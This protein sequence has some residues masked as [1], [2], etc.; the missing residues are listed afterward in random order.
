MFE[1]QKPQSNEMVIFLDVFDVTSK[2]I[3]I[4]ARR[5][6]N[7]TT[8]WLR[9]AIARKVAKENKLGVGLIR[10]SIHLEK[11]SGK[12]FSSELRLDRRAR[13]VSAFKLGRSKQTKKGVRVRG[14]FYDDAFIGTMPKTGHKGIFR[15][16]GKERLPLQEMYFVIAPAV[17]AAMDEYVGDKGQKYLERA[18]NHELKFVMSK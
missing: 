10:K 12:K 17:Q 13:V 8:R 3:Q 14:R 1:I 18:F 6:I 9:S 5:A 4:A 16:K 2:Q 11:A 15:R 7:K